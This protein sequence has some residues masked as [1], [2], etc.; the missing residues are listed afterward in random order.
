M[1]KSTAPVQSIVAADVRTYFNANP[2]RLARLS[3]EARKTVE[4][5]DGKFPKGRLHPQAIKENN[6]SRP[7][8]QYVPGATAAAKAARDAN[9]KALRAAVGAKPKGPIPKAARPTE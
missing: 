7:T 9:Q 8:R 5:V 6:S 3:P 2:K 1:A 4:A